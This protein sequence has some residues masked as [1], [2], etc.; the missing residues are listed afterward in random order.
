MNLVAGRKSLGLAS[1]KYPSCSNISKKDDRELQ[2]HPETESSAPKSLKETENPPHIPLPVADAPI[3]PEV[4]GG[5]DA[6]VRGERRRYNFARPGSSDLALRFRTAARRGKLSVDGPAATADDARLPNR[7]DSAAA[8]GIASE[9]P[10]DASASAAT[11]DEV[12]S[13]TPP[14]PPIGHAAAARCVPRLSLPSPQP[15]E[16]EEP[17]RAAP[18]LG[19]DRARGSGRQDA[20]ADRSLAG[21]A[22]AAHRRRSGAARRRADDARPCRS[23]SRDRRSEAAD[24]FGPPAHRRLY[25]R[26]DFARSRR[27]IRLYLHDAGGKLVSADC[28]GAPDYRWRGGRSDGA[29]RSYDGSVGPNREDERLG[30]GVDDEFRVRT[31]E[32]DAVAFLVGREAAAVDEDAAVDEVETPVA[33]TLVDARHVGAG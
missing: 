24:H 30:T 10:Q 8:A 25:G 15:P 1:R 11:V 23:L 16:E 2:T 12:A 22:L 19:A 27:Q 29:G 14:A 3:V 33:C 9:L 6:S 32:S 31:G 17:E 18:L 20:G 13:L 28:A 7:T 4:D 5:G 26:A 21:P